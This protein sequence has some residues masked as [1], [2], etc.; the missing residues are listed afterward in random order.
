MALEM[1]EL[2]A[3]DVSDLFEFEGPDVVTTGSEPRQ[4]VE[5]TLRMPRHRLIPSSLVR[6][7]PRPLP[8][9]H[10]VTVPTNGVPRRHRSTRHARLL[11]Q[12]RWSSA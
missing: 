11:A 3:L 1:E 12:A 10:P 8:L 7:H 4:V 5:I 6:Q 9:V 2:L